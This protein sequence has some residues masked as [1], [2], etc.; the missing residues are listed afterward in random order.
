MRRRITRT[1]RQRALLD[2]A[3]GAYGEWRA[4]CV[5]VRNA[6]RRWKG[7]RAGEEPPAFTA[8]TAALDREEHAAKRYARV[9]RRAGHPLEGRTR[10]SAC[11]HRHHLSGGVASWAQ[12]LHI[13]KA[14]R[15]ELIPVAGAPTSCRLAV[16]IGLSTGAAASVPACA[17]HDCDRRVPAHRRRRGPQHP[18]R[19]RGRARSRAHHDRRAD[20]L[21]PSTR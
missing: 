5:E 20:A 10:R 7:A 14:R 13:T 18:D 16:Y 19:P 3:M 12:H 8:Y 1:A 15:S 4:E 17:S 6:Y 9:M 2:A 11:P 21:H